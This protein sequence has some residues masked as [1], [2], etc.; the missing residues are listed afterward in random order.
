MDENTI[1]W[2][3]FLYIRLLYYIKLFIYL[4][5]YINV[6]DKSLTSLIKSALDKVKKQQQ[7]MLRLQEEG[8]Q[9]FVEV[10]RF[11]ICLA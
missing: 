3:R 4:Y 1:L 2:N 11:P 6:L 7:I 9:T 10:S 8:Y 5:F